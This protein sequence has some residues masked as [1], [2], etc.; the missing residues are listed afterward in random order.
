[1]VLTLKKWFTTNVCGKPSNPFFS[2]KPLKNELI[3]LVK[4]GNLVF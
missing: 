4:K 2:D 3:A 1:M